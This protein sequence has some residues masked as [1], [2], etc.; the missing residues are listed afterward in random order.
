MMRKTGFSILEIMMVLSIIAILAGIGIPRLKGMQDDTNITKAKA[1]LQMLKTALE[2]FYNNALPHAYP[3]TTATL[4]D[5]LAAAPSQIAPK[6]PAYDPFGATATTQYSYILNGKY[7]VIFSV[8][9]DRT[10]QTTAISSAGV[11][12]TSGDDICV[13]NGQGCGD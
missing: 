13:T 10:V 6:T 1:E 11:V 9:I 3:A 8:G 4:G 2:A 5:V 12:T 7:Y